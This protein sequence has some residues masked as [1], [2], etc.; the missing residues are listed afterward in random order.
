MSNNDDCDDHLLSHILSNFLPT[1]F[2]SQLPHNHR[3][4]SDW[5]T[6]VSSLTTPFFYSLCVFLSSTSGVLQIPHWHCLVSLHLSTYFG[7]ILCL[8]RFEYLDQQG[9]DG[10]F[11]TLQSEMMP[12]LLEF[13][14]SGSSML[15]TC[16]MPK[17]KMTR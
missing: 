11:K 8:T 16:Y 2:S 5:N 10:V 13:H 12:K 1:I 15:T 17:G 9:E 6:L 3:F 4:E 14:T 7:L